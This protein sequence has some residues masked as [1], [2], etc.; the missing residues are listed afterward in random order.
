EFIKETPAPDFCIKA[1]TLFNLH[2]LPKEDQL[3]IEQDWNVIVSKIKDGKAEELSDSLTKYLGATTKGSKTEKNMTTQPFSEVKAHRRSFTLKGSYMTEL[4]RMIMSGKYKE[5]S[6]YVEQEEKLFV[7]E[8]KLD[9]YTPEPI[10]KNIEQL[11]VKTFEEIIIEQF[12]PYVNKT[13]RE[14]GKIFD[15]EIPK[16]NDKASTPILAKK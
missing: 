6:E 15:V 4:A 12:E 11:K 9:Y 5:P 7:A 14:L 3:I 10:I 16:K 2:D 1:A 8:T 13:K